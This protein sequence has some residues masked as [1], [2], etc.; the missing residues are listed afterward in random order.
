VSICLKKK[1]KRE[2]GTFELCLIPLFLM[3]NSCNRL[4]LMRI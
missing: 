4:V 2:G 3:K 1:K